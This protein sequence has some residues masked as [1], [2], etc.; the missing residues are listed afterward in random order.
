MTPPRPTA[1]SLITALGN[2]SRRSGR[3][4]GPQ[5]MNA[6][7]VERLGEWAVKFKESANHCKLLEKPRKRNYPRRPSEAE[8]SQ[9]FK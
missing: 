1:D 2:A 8:E 7:D 5:K 6:D 3:D 4:R 9:T